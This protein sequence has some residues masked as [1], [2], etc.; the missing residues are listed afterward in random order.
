MKYEKHKKSYSV[1][2]H[3]DED[4]VSDRKTYVQKFFADEIFEHCW[5]QMTKVK[6]L[7]L[8]FN[9]QIHRIHIK[10]E[11]CGDLPDISTKIN[12]Y[13]ETKRTHFY[14]LSEGNIQMV[15]MHVDDLYSYNDTTNDLLPLLGPYGGSLSVRLPSEQK[16]II[17][18]GQDEA[19]F[20]SSQLNDSCWTI[21]GESTLCTKGLGTGIMVSAMVSRAFGMGLEITEAQ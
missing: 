6:Y 14:T 3:E 15:E 20:R 19:I 12:D 2:R 18:F 17:T 9:E 16:P 13:I 11:R 5:I 4:V 21:D 10:K 8:T 1:D 7:A